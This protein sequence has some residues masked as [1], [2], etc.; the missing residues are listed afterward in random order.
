MRSAS[1]PGMQHS[2]RTELTRVWGVLSGHEGC[3]GRSAQCRHVVAVQDD[4]VVGQRVDIWRRDLRRAVEP[5]VIPPLDTS[6]NT[7]KQPFGDN[8]EKTCH[9]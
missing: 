4:A 7:A 1:V 3:S 8:L 5:H 6:D 9:A 2:T